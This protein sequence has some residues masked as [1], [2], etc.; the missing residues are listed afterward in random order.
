MGQ[1]ATKL[2]TKPEDTKIPLWLKLEAKETGLSPLTQMSTELEKSLAEDSL[3]WWKKW[4]TM[5]RS[6]P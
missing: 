5:E 3:Q 4:S 2:K 6:V 1:T